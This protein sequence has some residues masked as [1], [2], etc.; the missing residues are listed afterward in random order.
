MTDQQT[1]GII[2]WFLALIPS[3]PEVQARA[4]E[5][6]DRVIGREHW[7]SAE[8]EIRLPYIR[9]IIKEVRCL[10]FLSIF[11]LQIYEGSTCPRTILDGN[12]TLFNRRLR[13]QWHVYSQGH[14]PGPQLL[15]STP[16]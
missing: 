16:Q 14:R 7:P 13:V 5:E 2:Q 4:H 11:D 15:H 3:H 9:A 1:A 8:D 6:L 10:S 12:S